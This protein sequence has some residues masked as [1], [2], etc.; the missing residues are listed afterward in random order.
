MTN[1]L[2]QLKKQVKINL[3]P[4]DLKLVMGTEGQISLQEAELLYDLAKGVDKNSVIVEIGSFRG[5]S[6]VALALGTKSGQGC[7]IY[8]IDPHFNF[9]GIKGG[10][11]SEKDMAALY[12]NLT[13]A[14][15]GDKVAVI[16]L[17]SLQI[18]QSWNDKNIGLLWLDGDHKYESVKADFESWLPFLV[19]GALVVLDDVDCEDVIRLAQEIEQRKNFSSVNTVGKIKYFQYNL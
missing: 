19:N 11:F 6:T 18:A 4:H 7:R 8:A 12:K 9:T 3:L 5:R 17:P 13:R 1:L 14:N 16:C 10:K 15:V 2:T